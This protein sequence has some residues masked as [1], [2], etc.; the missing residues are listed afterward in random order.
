VWLVAIRGDT[1]RHTVE[2]TFVNGNLVYDNGSVI[3]S[4]FGKALTFDRKSAAAY[5]PDMA[6]ILYLCA[7]SRSNNCEI[8]IY[9]TGEGRGHFTQSLALASM[10]RKHGHEVVAVLVGKDDHGRFPV[11]SRKDRSSRFDFRSPISLRYTAKRP[12]WC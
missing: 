4:A 6:I 9:C 10:L 12:N 3:E 7:K 8:P 2:K 1:F 11:L 5:G